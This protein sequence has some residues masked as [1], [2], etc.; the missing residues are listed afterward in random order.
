VEKPSGETSPVEP[1]EEL[2]RNQTSTLTTND[3]LPL[4]ELLYPCQALD[5][6]GLQ[7]SQW[8]VHRYVSGGFD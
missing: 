3:E 7:L 6:D 8:V 4:S 5:V 2:Q 1:S